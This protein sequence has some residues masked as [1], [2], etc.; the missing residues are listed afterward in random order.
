MHVLHCRLFFI[1]TRWGK[2]RTHDLADDG[3]GQISREH[4]AAHGV[5]SEVSSLAEAE[6]D[7]I[8]L[9]EGIDPVTVQVILD[10]WER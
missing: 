1:P 8:E 7:R 3:P 10:H 2:I 5:Q 9:E 6:F 4:L